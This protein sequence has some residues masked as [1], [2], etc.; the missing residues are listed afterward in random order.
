MDGRVAKRALGAGTLVRSSDLVRPEIVG[1][2]DIVTVVYDGPGVNLSMRAKAT[3][4]GALGDT[5]NVINP[6]SKKTL[7]AVVTG[8]GRVS[9][10]TSSAAPARLANAGAP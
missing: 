10:G 3:E 9:V 4:A 6:S 7:Q 1:R 5:V 8:P 2:G